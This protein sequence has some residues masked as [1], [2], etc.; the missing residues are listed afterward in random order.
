MKPIQRLAQFASTAVC[1]ESA[2]S[3]LLQQIR[4]AQEQGKIS[5]NV[6]VFPGFCDVH[7]HLREP[8]QTYKET[9]ATGTA[10]CARG[11]F[12]TVGAMPN[13]DPVPD[14]LPALELELA[15]IK[16]SSLIETLPYA[17]FTKNE[18]GV[19]LS[20]IAELAPQ[21]IGFSDDGHGVDGTALMQK[22]L[23]QLA[24]A[25]SIIAVH[26]EDG[27]LR[28]QNSCINDGPY[29]AK[30]G[31]I[32][33]PKTAEYRQI[34]RDIQLLRE[35]KAAGIMPKYHVCHISCGE[36][37]DLIRQARAEGLDVSCETAMHYLLI[38][39]SMLIDDGRFKMNPPL[40]EP[41]DRIALIA[42]LIDGTIEMIATDH[43]P[44]S[45]A[46]KS[47][48]LRDSAFG[49]VGVEISFPLF[50]THFVR[51]EKISLERAIE[52]FSTVGRN[53]FGIPARDNDFTIWDLDAQYEIDPQ[54]FLS[55]G[56]ATPFAGQKV[57]GKCLATF[58]NGTMVYQDPIFSA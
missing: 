32:G 58:H 4:A 11:G 12:T 24:K 1:S 41:A 2:A 39:E 28:P 20:D 51:T 26:A 22:G 42:A 43:A 49:V 7:V 27:E 56:R 53:R 15:A 52:L 25:G 45:T 16:R 48:G 35:L 10:A 9:I 33:I 40:R 31:L 30:H 37:A 38:D 14:S 44:H 21:V 47:R 8:G 36:S 17:A 46:E 50:Y 55:L 3:V 29:A 19:E 23:Q 57:F 13:L 5:Q 18:A 34:E 54:D 6:A